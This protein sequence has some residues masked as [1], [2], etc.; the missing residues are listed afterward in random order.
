MI[1]EDL[2]LEARKTWH[3]Y[4]EVICEAFMFPPGSAI[5]ADGVEL[6][7]NSASEQR[8]HRFISYVRSEIE[9]LRSAKFMDED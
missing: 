4:G 3:E 6:M 9:E 8:V 2:K 5:V 7:L 1:S